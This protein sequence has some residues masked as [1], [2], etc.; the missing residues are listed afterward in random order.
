MLAAIQ[1]VVGFEVRRTRTRGRI[2]IWLGLAL[3]PSLLMILLQAQARGVV[4]DEPLAMMA[5]YLVVQV[6]CMLGLLLWAT[7]VVGA[8]LESQTW[9]YVALRQHGKTAILL[10]K[11]MVAT[12][13]TASAGIVS[14]VG[15]AFSSGYPE[16]WTLATALVVLVLVSSACYAALY[17]LI[18]VLFTARATVVA[19]I[20]TLLFEGVLSTIPAT[21]NKFT[22]CYRLR[23]LLSEWVGLTEVRTAVEELFGHE[24]PWQHLLCLAIFALTA[25]CVALAVVHYKEF[26]VSTDT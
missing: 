10:G 13:W 19:V 21:I 11:Y 14:A 2:G 5:Y 6:G 15:V 16:P 3:L 9:I 22:V 12:L 23:A 8:E 18:G 7:P 24:P 4:P 1:Q 26:P 17:V 20:Y 25:L